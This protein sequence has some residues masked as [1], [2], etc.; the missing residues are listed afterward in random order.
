LFLVFAITA[1]GPEPASDQ[2]LMRRLAARD[3]KAIEE[4]Y[5]RYSR[6]VFSV[7]LR[8]TGRAELAE[9]LLQET[10]L[11][12]WRNAESYRETRGELR[13]WLLTVA[14]NLAFDHRRTKVEQQRQREFHLEIVP[15]NPAGSPTEEIYAQRE[16]VRQVRE[17]IGTLPSPQQRALH[18]AYFEGMSQSEIARAMDEP[19]GTVKTWMRTALHQLREQLGATA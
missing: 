8:I 18:L 16:R 10:F 6:L 19:L 13:P 11:R 3:D 15:A 9:E 2:S 4:L 7:L 17:V 5:D 14:R 1:S 12:L